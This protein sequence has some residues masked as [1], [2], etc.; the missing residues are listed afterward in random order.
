[1]FVYIQGLNIV[2]TEI[3]AFRFVNTCLHLVYKLHRFGCTIDIP[4]STCSSWFIPRLMMENI[5]CY[6][7]CLCLEVYNYI[8]TCTALVIW[9]YYAIEQESS[10]LYRQG[11]DRYIP[12]KNGLGRWYAASTY[13]YFHECVCTMYI[14]I[15]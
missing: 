13:I 14:Q 6:K 12:S 15:S 11:S 1:M 9:M 2:L 8:L 3:R 7:H 5:L 4:V 10:I